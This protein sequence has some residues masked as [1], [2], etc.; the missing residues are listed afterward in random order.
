MII[1]KPYG[2]HTQ[3]RLLE[4]LSGKH[5]TQNPPE[6]MGINAAYASGRLTLEQAH[7]RL[8]ELITGWQRTAHR[9]IARSKSELFVEAFWT[10]SHKGAL[11]ERKNERAMST[12]RSGYFEVAKLLPSVDLETATPAEIKEALKKLDKEKQRVLTTRI[13]TMWRW[14]GR[15]ENQRLSLPKKTKKLSTDVGFMTLEEIAE[16]S[17]KLESPLNHFCMAMF[18]CGARPGEMFLLTPEELQEGGTHVRIDKTW[19]AKFKADTTKNDKT[20]TAYVIKECREAL[21]KWCEVSMEVRKDMWRKS[22]YS[23]TFQAAFDGNVPYILRHSY[24]HHMLSKGATLLHLRMWMRDD[25]RTIELYYLKWV[26]TS[27]EMRSNIKLF[28]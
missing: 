9:D 24:A 2:R 10:K 12:A 22:K 6:L 28:D 1:K 23:A 4:K 19:T 8:K 14:A 7:N 26:Q 18:G 13:N 20:G 5:Y 25:M 3:F 16:R 27:A 21:R 11:K 17:K 15:P